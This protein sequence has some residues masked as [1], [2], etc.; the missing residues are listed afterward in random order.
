MWGTAVNLAHQMR[1]GASDSGVYVT[2]EVYEVM[3]DIRQLPRR[4]ALP[5][6]ARTAES[7]DWRSASEAVEP[8]WLYWAGGLT[9]GA[10]FPLISLT[11]WHNFLRAGK[12]HWPAVNLL[13]T[14]SCRWRRCCCLDQGGAGA[15]QF[16]LVRVLATVFGSWCC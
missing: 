9:L 15:A 4:E 7:G 16:N 1:S 6:T 2:S 14:T 8:F 10:A 11:E 5:S 3:R 12:A 13:R